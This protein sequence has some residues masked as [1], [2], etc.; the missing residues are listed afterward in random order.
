MGESIGVRR[1]AGPFV[2]WRTVDR[3]VVY[4]LLCLKPTE[5]IAT[6]LARVCMKANT[7]EERQAEMLRA[8]ESTKIWTREGRV[9][10]FNEICRWCPHVASRRALL[11]ELRTRGFLIQNDTADSG[12]TKADD[13]S[14]SAAELPASPMASSSSL[15]RN[16]PVKTSPTQHWRLTQAGNG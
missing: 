2:L 15:L 9:W 1:C 6:H 4:C 8:K 3:R 10:D 12:T 14:T 13:P 16:C 5:T 11:R 7:P